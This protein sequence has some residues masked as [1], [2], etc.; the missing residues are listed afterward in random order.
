MAKKK[1]IVSESDNK[2]MLGKINRE[3]DEGR[4]SKMEYEMWIAIC[5]GEKIGY[6]QKGVR[7]NK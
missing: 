3:Y 1:E 2:K 5:K 6:Q 7:K 4:L